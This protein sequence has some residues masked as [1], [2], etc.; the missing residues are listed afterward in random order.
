[1]SIHWSKRNHKINSLAQHLGLK[2][3]QVISFDLPAGWTCPGADICKSQT[4]RI[5]G[6][7][8]DGENCQFRCYA[9]SIES[10]AA[11]VR[12]A[13]WS[14]FDTIKTLSTDEIVKVI[15]DSIPNDIKI[16]R[17]HSSGDFFNKAYFNAWVKIASLNPDI[18]FFG[19]TK[20]I[21]YV[22]AVKPDNFKLVYSYG[23]KMDSKLTNEPTVY[24]I[25]DKAEAIG[26]RLDVV[27]QENDWDDF[28]AIMS[29]KTFAIVLHG[30]QP[31][32]A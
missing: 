29:G 16:I 26:K 21:Q 27:C 9:A 23:G 11:N 14:N 18:T 28:Q 10:Y 20:V 19:Y 13:H 17:I 1:M 5:T 6:K 8:T 30:T 31:A 3:S 32:K 2:Q 22:N 25:K 15:N 4:N 7:I 24:V 12:K